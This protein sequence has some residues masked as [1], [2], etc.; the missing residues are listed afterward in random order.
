MRISRVCPPPGA[1]STPLIWLHIGLL[2]YEKRLEQD[3]VI[4]SSLS[5]MLPLAP[6]SSMMITPSISS[7]RL[8]VGPAFEAS[9]NTEGTTPPFDD[10]TPR[11]CAYL[12][13]HSSP[14]SLD[15]IIHRNLT[16]II[17]PILSRKR[18]SRSTGAPSIRHF[19]QP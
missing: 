17:L 4:R 1:P 8:N 5:R 6:G 14:Q 9:F 2:H 11:D 13:W 12:I 16:R 7:E 19:P 3:R 18:K 15:G 10:G